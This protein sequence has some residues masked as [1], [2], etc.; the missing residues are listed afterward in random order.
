METIK[1]T[2]VQ[3]AIRLNGGYSGLAEKLDITYQSVQQW[4][5]Q[6]FVPSKRCLKV[7]EL[8]HGEVTTH[9]LN[10]QVFGKPEDAAA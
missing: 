9:D 4:E 7:V 6:G 5:K 8:C 1:E 2:G 10:P 3:K